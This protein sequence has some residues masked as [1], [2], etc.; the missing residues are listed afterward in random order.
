MTQNRWSM[1]SLTM[2]LVLIALCGSIAAWGRK[3]PA[4]TIAT[5]DGS[6]VRTVYI[7]S[8]IPDATTSIAA[9][10]TQ[11]T[12]LTLAPSVKQADAVLNVGVALPT[13]DD[14]SSTPQTLGNSKGGHVHASSFSCSDDKSSGGCTSTSKTDAGNL[15]GVSSQAGPGR[16]AV[17]YDISLATVQHE[18]S[19]LWEPDAH[20]KFPWAEQL[21]AAAG[22]PVCPGEHFDR[23]KDKSYREWIATRCPAMLQTQ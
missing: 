21:R 13:V 8:S 10:L 18:A 1:R 2:C 6:P 5:P 9:Q 4:K 3:K 23:K 11:D 20:S 17:N 12:C 16:Q 14:G 22:C 15:N 19:E 7:Q